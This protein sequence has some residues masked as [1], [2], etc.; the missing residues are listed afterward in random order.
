M[1]FDIF[2]SIA[3]TPVRGYLPDERTMLGNFLDQA[4][5]AD[6][7]GYG[8]VWVAESHYS[9]QLQKTHRQP[10]VPHWQGEIGLNTDICQ[11]APQVFTRTRRVN[12]G[13]AIMNV[14][15][16]GGPLAAAERVATALSWHGLDPGERRRLYLGFS[17]GRFDYINR[18]TGVDARSEWERLAWPQVKR[19]VVAEATEIFVRMLA[20]EA[21]SSD[22]VP[23]AV[24]CR[25]DFPDDATWSS[26]RAAAPGVGEGVRVPRRWTFERTAIVP[27]DWRRDLL[28]LVLGSHDPDLQVRANRF[29]PVRVFNLSITPPEVIDATHERMRAH[30]HPDGGPWRR[31]YMPRTT[32]VFLDADAARS[33]ARQREHAHEEATAALGAYWQALEGTLDPERVRRDVSNALI[34]NPQ[35]VAEQ[36]AARFHPDDRLMLWFDFFNHD[37][38]RVIEAMRALVEHVLPRLAALGVPVHHPT[39]ATT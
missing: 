22:D 28:R 16:N 31:S 11:L 19:A 5:A 37:N 25:A 34:G 3:R 30:F 36:I 33:C 9:T 12:V 32:F 10:V 18:L 17:G 23:E 38:E 8:T 24:L 29:A 21:F 1:R 13:S 14:V 27:A 15:C 7:L 39:P 26:V 35:D 20:G 6:E 2:C 4:R